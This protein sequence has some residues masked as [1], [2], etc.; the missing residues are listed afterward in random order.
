MKYLYILG[1]LIILFQNVLFLNQFLACN[2]FLGYFPKL[3]R[4]L[5]LAF[6]A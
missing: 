1:F 4:G 5:G 6:S 3:K 2:C